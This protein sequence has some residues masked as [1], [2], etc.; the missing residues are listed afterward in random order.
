MKSSAYIC[1]ELKPNTMSKEKKQWKTVLV[2]RVDKS[3]W[4]LPTLAVS[5]YSGVVVN[6]MKIDPDT[7]EGIGEVVVKASHFKEG[8][9]RRTWQM[10]TFVPVDGKLEKVGVIKKVV[11]K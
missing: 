2:D 4:T 11:T 6:M 8:D 10:R 7:G 5:T 3:E 1:R 9:F